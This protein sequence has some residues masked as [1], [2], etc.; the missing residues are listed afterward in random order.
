MFGSMK[1]KGHKQKSQCRL[2]SSLS[3]EW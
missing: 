2:R 3:D 1:T